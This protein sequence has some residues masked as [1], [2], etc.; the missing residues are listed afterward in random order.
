MI[1]TYK[2]PLYKTNK[3]HRLDRIVTTAARIKNHCIAFHKTYYKLFG[4]HCHKFKLMKHIAKIRNRRQDWKI[5]GSQC[6]QD[7]IE[8]LDLTYQAFFKW[9][10][11]RTGSKRGTPKFK[12]SAGYG[13]VTF[14]QA[15]W[16]YLGENQIRFGKYIYKFVKSR[17]IEGKIKTCTLKRDNM[18][19]FWVTFSCEEEDLVQIA[20][21]TKTAGFD[22]GLKNFLTC[23][24]GTTI[25]NPLFFKTSMA[26]LKHCNKALSTKKNGSNNRKKAKYRL[27][28]LYEKITN[29]RNDWFFKL[30]HSLCDKFDRMYF[31]TLNIDAMKKLWGRK[32]SDLAFGEFLT[33]LKWIAYKRGKLVT[34]VGKWE[35]TTKTCSKCGHTQDVPLNIR[36]FNCES[37]NL[38]IGRDLNAAFNIKCLGHQAD[39]LGNVSLDFGQAVS[40]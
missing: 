17:D 22:F 33:I 25:N 21:S 1:K 39:G 8:K 29:R 32:V 36:V 37:C 16:A 4:K 24:D 7:I 23:S 18:G 6:V 13:S 9:I 3:C 10:K 38:S 28:R 5:V 34:Q 27:S 15:G 19:K 30:A 35:P 26:E 40:V 2:F 31:E 20:D 14:R 11:H 12:S